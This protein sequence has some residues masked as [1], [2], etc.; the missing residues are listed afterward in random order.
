MLDS[1]QEHFYAIVNK[2]NANDGAIQVLFTLALV[3]FAILGWWV[4][5][6]QAFNSVL[7]APVFDF[8]KNEGYR[9][10]TI[11]VRNVGL[12]PAINTTLTWQPADDSEHS[13]LPVRR[14]NYVAIEA[15]GQETYADTPSLSMQVTNKTGDPPW[16]EVTTLG[17]LTATYQDVHE[18]QGKL[19]AT[20]VLTVEET[21]SRASR[22][23]SFDF[24]DNRLPEDR[25]RRLIKLRWIRDRI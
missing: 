20:L 18:R 17:T 1:I 14:T 4:A 16:Q 5:R 19:V 15:G 23:V 24:A 7:P 22:V 2:A 3:L 21:P 25:F 11:I 6:Q 10:P 9:T 8:V 12:G 13:Q